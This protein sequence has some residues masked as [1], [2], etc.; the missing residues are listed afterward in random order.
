MEVMESDLIFRDFVLSG[1]WPDA[2]EFGPQRHSAV[3]DDVDIKSFGQLVEG[4]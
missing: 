3:N 1:Y 2:L 4:A